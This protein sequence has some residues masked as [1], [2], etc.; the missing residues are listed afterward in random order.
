VRKL[1]RLAAAFDRLTIDLVHDQRE[2][3]VGVV[4]RNRRKRVAR[5]VSCGPRFAVQEKVARLDVRVAVAPVLRRLQH[6]RVVDV[7]LIDV[8]PHEKV[9]GLAERAGQGG[10]QR[11]RGDAARARDLGQRGAV[12]FHAAYRIGLPACREAPRGRNRAPRADDEPIDVKGLTRLGR[13]TRGVAVDDRLGAE[14]ARLVDAPTL[15]EVV[16]ARGRAREEQREN[17][18]LHSSP[19]IPRLGRIGIP[20]R[21]FLAE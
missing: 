1:H 12:A 3:V 17:D 15:T 2:I 16:V 11:N 14:H 13:C 7:G 5:A 10:R 9:R 19:R 21:S 4:G 20:G 6:H 8:A 18:A